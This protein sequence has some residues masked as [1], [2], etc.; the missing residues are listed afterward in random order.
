MSDRLSLLARVQRLPAEPFEPLALAV[1]RYQA[2][3]NPV[4]RAYLQY[5]RIDPAAVRDW[6]AIPFLP[7]EL[8]KTQRVVTG[9][10]PTPLVFESSGTTGTQTSRHFVAAPDFYRDHSIRLFEAAYGPLAGYHVLALLPS[11]LERGG[12]SLV[13][14]VQAFI[15][16]TGSA[17]SGFFLH[18]LP[19]LRQTLHERLTQSDGRRVLLLGVTYALLDLAES[20]PLAL[21]QPERLLV[22]E[23]GGM[24]GRRR[25]LLRE[26]VHAALTAALGVPVVHSEYGMTEL[27]SQAYSAGEGLFRVP[28]SMRVL[29]RDPNDPLTLLGPTGRAGG[30]NV[31]DLANVDSCAFL[32]TKD[33]G[34]YGPA[35]GTF[36][37]LGRFDNA[38]VRGCN[39]LVA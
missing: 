18:D 5:R 21:P 35:P 39:L 25:E 7:I 2:A 28:A 6:T 3:Q 12:S 33:L 19:A 27:L 4:Y 17:H 1:F 8:F 38:D 36:R 23:T 37:V 11:Y 10:V 29:L 20:G 34:Q 26:E 32:E 15:E 31:V 13:Y 30:L 14:M 9:E 24:K 22:M 16:R